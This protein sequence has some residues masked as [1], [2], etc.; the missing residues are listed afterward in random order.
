[1]AGGEELKTFIESQRPRV[2]AVER[3]RENEE[4][5]VRYG[6]LFAPA[7]IPNLTAE[8]FKSFLAFKNNKHW[9]GIQRQ[10][11]LLTRD[12]NRLR[13]ALGILVDE[14]K[15]L[16]ERLETICPK[17]QP[18]FV[19]GLARAV[20]TPILAVVYPERYGVF[21][22]KSERAL[23]HF[24]LFPHLEHGASFADQY[25]AVNEVL[26]RL[27]RKYKLTLLEL[28]EVFGWFSPGGE[29]E[30]LFPAEHAQVVPEG[31]QFWKISPG[32]GAYLWNKFV[33]L[34]CI[35]TGNFR[36]LGSDLRAFSSRDEIQTWLTQQGVPGN[37]G[38]KSKQLWWIRS[39][40][41]VGDIVFA[42]GGKSILGVAEV[43]GEYEFIEDEIMKYAHRRRVKWHSEQSRPIHSL[44]ASLRRKLQRNE[45][46]VQLTQEEGATI[47][48]LYPEISLS[49]PASSSYLIKYLASSGLR[50][51]PHQ[52][53]TFATALQTKGFVILSGISGTG[54]TRLA[55]Y[56]ADLMLNP[57]PSNLP[58][59]HPS[60][61][62]FVP[63]R[64]D[65]RDSKSLL[66]YYNPLTEKFESTGFLRFI[67][68]AIAHYN[69]YGPEAL[70]YFVIL[71]EMNLARVE[72][73]LAEF[74][75]VLESDRDDDRKTREAVALH[76]FRQPISDADDRPIPPAVRLP[77]NLYFVGT[78]NVD[79]TTHAFSPK[80]LDR[81]FTIELTEAD[82]S[83][84]PPQLDAGSQQ[85]SE[86][87]RAALVRAFT[88]Q[89]RFAVV[90][91]DS[92]SEF[93]AAHPQ[94]RTHL[95]NLSELLRP[96][97]LHFAY[98]VF[99]EI[100]AFCANAASA[101]W[102]DG[103]RDLDDAFDTA[104]LMKIL[105]KFHGS[106]GRLLGPLRRV[107]AWTQQ[108]DDPNTALSAVRNYED[109]D[110][111]ISLRRALD[112]LLDQSNLP[113]SQPSNLLP[114]VYPRT[115]R[116]AIRMLRELYD[117]GFASFS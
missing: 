69:E 95:Q 76:T 62:L 17:G 75:S 23:K 96:Y 67:L 28:D 42:Y 91:K 104:V 34:E 90:D 46:I 20:A 60:N 72:H 101:P 85:L 7:N 63:V 55:Q 39:G 29:I 106:R 89:G 112:G 92:V 61:S 93:V 66:G 22:D 33:Q 116:K 24:G 56:F 105:P 26:N 79:E 11:G 54:K 1:M 111:C 65:W 107:L 15:P 97:D 102:F 58:S 98:R 68:R 57:Q 100:A 47:L 25:I 4:M 21:N 49:C 70:I 110:A 73:Y 18:G 115:A 3:R 50:F 109:A 43:T 31:I 103:F 108:P 14:E 99:D 27:A 44:T 12:M 48:S 16:R 94:Y 117:T 2:A 80:V 82:F 83:D 45:T 10:G 64:P 86:E 88:R 114:L 74:L 35:A 52:L 37:L 40:I 6:Q 19:K 30:A 113:T 59:S 71:D 5:L 77:P 36:G 51:T 8:E 32:E 84:Y 78:V 53:A 81:A 87:Q 38:Y 9:T 41:Q 13:E